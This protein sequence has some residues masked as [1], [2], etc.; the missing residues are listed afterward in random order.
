[1]SSSAA[2]ARLVEYEQAPEE[3]RAVFDDIKR[4]RN[5]PDVNNFWKALARHPDTLRRTWATLKEV[6]APGALDARTKEMLYLA[7]SLANGCAYCVAS[8]ERAAR[9]QGMTEAMYAE[10]LAVVAQ[11]CETNLLAEAYRVPLDE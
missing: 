7:V 9:K 10:L 11:A 4:T 6:M 1:M 3:V 5:V 2:S 8:H